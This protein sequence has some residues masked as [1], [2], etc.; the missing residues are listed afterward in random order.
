MV[1]PGPGP[2][3]RPPLAGPPVAGYLE[4]RMGGGA[5]NPVAEGATVQRRRSTGRRPVGAAGLAAALLLGVM[6]LPAPG[7]APAPKARSGPRPAPPARPKPANL[8]DGPMV[9]SAEAAAAARGKPAEKDR[10]GGQPDWREV[11]PWRQASYFGLRAEGQVFIF[12]VDCSG[13]MDDE[14][15]LDRAK[16]ELIRSV[17]AMQSPQR[18]KVI[19][20]NEGPVPMPGELPKPADYPSKVQLAR[21][22]DYVQPGGGT[23]PRSSLALALAMKPDGIFLLSDGAFPEGA[24]A[25][26][27]RRN[28]KKIPIHCIDLAG[29]AAGDD[30]RRIARD[31]GGQYAARGR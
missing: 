23:D 3:P 7:Q 22:L 4:T 18:F 9:M 17:R 15:R 28:P 14:A 5:R 6:T 11:P 19:F 16:A 29:G 24:A 1:R 13:S 26:V 31:S 30:L 2:K 10:Y 21:W 25:D 12:V 8:D 20:F 27:A